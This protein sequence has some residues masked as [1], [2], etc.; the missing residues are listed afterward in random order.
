MALNRKSKMNE[1][2]EN[3]EAYAILRK[4]VPTC[5]KEAPGMAAALGM[6][7]QALL[8]FPATK[9]PKA[10]REAFFAELEAANIG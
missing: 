2:F 6:S 1:I 9:C 10:T 3:E 4:H 7:A 5:V 8:S